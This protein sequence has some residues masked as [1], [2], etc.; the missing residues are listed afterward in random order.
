LVMCASLIAGGSQ[1]VVWGRAGLESLVAERFADRGTAFSLGTVCI[2]DLALVQKGSTF[3][4]DECYYKVFFIRHD[5]RAWL[6]QLTA[7]V[8]AALAPVQPMLAPPLPNAMGHHATAGTQ[9]ATSGAVAVPGMAGSEL[10]LDSPVDSP[11]NGD[12][13][14]AYLHQGLVLAM[15]AYDLGGCRLRVWGRAGLVDLVA[16]LSVARCVVPSSGTV[17][18]RDLAGAQEGSV[19]VFDGH[20]YVV[21]F[22]LDDTRTWERQL[23]EAAPA[24]HARSLPGLGPPPAAA[25]LLF[26][27]AGGPPCGCWHAGGDLGVGRCA[28][29]G[30]Q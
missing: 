23:A 15:C 18:L 9:V 25:R 4:Y 27:A 13:T 28:W 20:G 16:E 5:V 6:R 30:W 29:G 3:I 12:P 21:N 17:S 22:F 24:I 19:F 26:G 11:E 10:Q 1:L 8:F 14:I 2:W 7:E